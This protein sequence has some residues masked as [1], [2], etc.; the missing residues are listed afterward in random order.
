MS[1]YQELINECFDQNKKQSV[2]SMSD[3]LM[4]WQGKEAEFN[5]LSIEQKAQYADFATKK[6]CSEHADATLK[7]LNDNVIPALPTMDA[8]LLNTISRA[9]YACMLMLLDNTDRAQ[10]E[11]YLQ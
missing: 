10:Y 2:Q 1:T 11:V 4:K 7:E 6:V 5:K 9:K 3:T 8:S